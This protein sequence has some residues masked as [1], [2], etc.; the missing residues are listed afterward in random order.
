ML[1]RPDLINIKELS[2]NKQRKPVWCWHKKRNIDQWNRTESP[3]MNPR[4]YSQLMTKETR[5]C[6]GEK[7]VSSII[8]AGK[9]GQLQ[10]HVKDEIRTLF[11]TTHKYKL[12]VD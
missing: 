10:L 3:E 6:S 1:F 12:K 9:T 2:T 8:V 4:T 5:L 11:N 7:T